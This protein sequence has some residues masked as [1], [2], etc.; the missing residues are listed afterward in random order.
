MLNLIGDD[1]EDYLY[2]PFV[3]LKPIKSASLV[4]VFL[5]NVF[6]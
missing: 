4:D 5:S 6:L 1:M 2:V 3:S